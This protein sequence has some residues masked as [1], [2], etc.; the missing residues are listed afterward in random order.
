MT[1][2]FGSSVYTIALPARLAQASR[3]GTE[4]HESKRWVSAMAMLESARLAGCIVPIVF[5]DSRDCSRLIAWS[6]LQRVEVSESG[7]RYWIGPLWSVGR[8][9]PQALTL[10]H[11]GRKIAKDYRRPYA[12]CRT[13]EFIRR[14]A[15]SPRPWARCDE[16]LEE[17]REGERRLAV[18]VR[19]ER[20]TGRV[21][22]IKQ[23]WLESYGGRLPCGVCGFDFVEAYGEIGAG[24][25]EAHHVVP[26]ADAPADGRP[27]RV[28]DL[29]IV[30]ANCHRMLHRGPEFLSV[31]E[32]RG[33][34]SLA[35]RPRLRR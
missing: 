14:A 2:P 12:L 28:E 3:D 15:R 34:L 4:L 20:A 19:R 6:E 32:L 27:M 16:A 31:E 8:R 5:A 13:P 35:T 24:F 25:A 33:R 7:T 9:A 1:G 21:R 30:C 23:A 29:M 11:Q 22:Q 17:V 26:L 18:H 10:L